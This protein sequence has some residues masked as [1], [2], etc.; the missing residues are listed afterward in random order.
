ML[1][2][3]PGCTARISSARRAARIHLRVVHTAADRGSS[4]HRICEISHDLRHRHSLHRRSRRTRRRIL[5]LRSRRNLWR[6]V[7]LGWRRKRRH[8]GRRAL[9][10]QLLCELHLAFS[11]KDVGEE[12]IVEL[13]S[14]R[15]TILV[16]LHDSA[17]GARAAVMWLDDNHA[18]AQLRPR[19][20][21]HQP[22]LRFLE[23]A[24]HI[25]VG[26]LYLVRL[27]VAVVMDHHALRPN[28]LGTEACSVQ[29]LH[30][31]AQPRPRR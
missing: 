31:I 14:K 21:L 26:H 11:V 22:H 16:V 15:L 6:P 4:G 9:L 20:S 25:A 28:V 10:Q 23:E 5:K 17:N 29:D 2:R 1:Q 7:L 18:V 12:A 27:R 30:A 13:E 19:A 24:N 3:L 8:V